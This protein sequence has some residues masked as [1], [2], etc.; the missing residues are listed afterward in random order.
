MPIKQSKFIVVSCFACCMV[1][2][3][4]AQPSANWYFGNKAAIKF[5]P[6]GPV[7]IT[8]SQMST[9]E[10]CS[11]ISDENGNLLFY[12]DGQ[13]VWNKNHD[14]MV[15]GT[16]LKGGSSSAQSSIVLPAPGFLNRYYIFTAAQNGDIDRY[17]CYNIVEMGLQGGLGEVVQKNIVFDTICSERIT[18]ATHSNG[19]D[20]WVITNNL[21]SNTFKAFKL[22]NTG[23]S[24]MPIVTNIGRNV[25]QVIGM[26]KVSPDGKWL[27]QTTFGTNL[28]TQLFKFD[29]NT[30]ILSNCI[31]LNI[32]FDCP[33]GCS[34]SPNSK[35]LYIG[36]WVSCPLNSNNALL[37]FT[38]DSEMESVINTSRTFIP[39][40]SISFW[41]LG[42][43]S[44][45][46]DN[47]IYIARS[48][49]ERLS[50]LNN[51]NDTATNIIFTDIAVA[52]PS[53]T[54]SYYGLPNFYNSIN[55]PPQI[56]I[57]I[58]TV[59]CLTY[60]FS[61]SSSTNY[62]YQGIYKWDFGD[63]SMQSNDSIAT[64]SFVRT[65]N[66][67]FLVKFNF[68]SP[69]SSLN[70]NLQRWLVLPKKPVA[71]FSAIT[72]GCIRDSVGFINN[73]TSTNGLIINQYNWWLGDGSTNNTFAPVKKYADTGTYVIQLLVKDT[74]GCIS[75]TGR[76]TLVLNK[77]TIANFELQGPYCTGVALLATD[78][79]KAYNTSIANW[80][81]GW[82]NGNTYSSTTGGNFTP[83][84]T[85]EGWFTIKAVVNSLEGCLSDTLVKNYFIYNKPIANFILPKSCVLD[86]SNF[87]NSSS[88]AGISN[89]NYW[90]WDFGISNTLTDT[91]RTANTSYQYN[92]AA[93][94]PVKL[95]VKTTEGCTDSITQ[96]FTVNGALPKPK[97]NFINNPI[98]GRDS[99]TFFNQSTVDFGSI[100]R[101]EINWGA[102]INI[103]NNP[104]LNTIY[105][106]K[107]PAF[108]TPAS[109]V[110]PI[111]FKAYS[112][113]SCV[114]ELDTFIV[115]KAQPKVSFTLPQATICGNDLPLLLNQGM[116]LNGAL[117]TFS[118]G[119]TGVNTLSNNVYQFSPNSVTPNNSIN[120][121]YKFTTP[122]GCTDSVNQSIQVLPYPT[123]NAGPDRTMLE[124]GQIVVLATANG[125]GLR[126]LWTPVQFTNN[127]NLLQPTI[128]INRDTS[129]WLTITNNVGCVDSSSVKIKVIGSLVVP[130]AFSPNNDG[131]ND[132][133]VI[134][135]LETYTNCEV[136]I[137]NRQGQQIFSSI[138]YNTPWDGTLNGQP[139]PIG[140]YYYIINPRKGRSRYTGWVQL[141]R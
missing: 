125:T 98:C 103:D 119:G 89:I 18:A 123:A 136:L 50:C 141:I 80:W 128:S 17:Y 16:G 34:F 19:T 41:R 26:C 22:S 108:G 7:A 11:T 38:I 76:L 35:R 8:G 4:I 28:P 75:D 93:Q 70:I 110:Q 32:P 47:K 91:A 104:A 86:N 111:K 30:G 132:K 23:L 9:L 137:F 65:A 87:I 36:S 13:T 27:I 67:S 2:L 92:S 94:Y 14:V 61:F 1:L 39:I 29:S 133:W 69:D 56:N 105:Q 113:I 3:G 90:K 62:N 5:T 139:L 107:Y 53:P 12:T 96:N 106:Y 99:V 118:Y 120:I 10:G 83:T 55:V 81:Y 58:D 6:T 95:W 101:T 31:N 43:L 24:S 44:I 88:I 51:P 63:G 77:K 78:S 117:G 131:I 49:S 52:L 64:H 73:S 129:L 21:N 33:Y 40:P 100:T 116:E 126:Y 138:G 45:G 79:A 15:N 20:F 102:F 66:D 54:G 97:L 112:G 25:T 140:T 68:R 60:K 85:A 37:Q 46:L 84:F 74:L 124:G 59:S 72:N 134:P 114:S 115:L 109:I 121:Q 130:N 127:P 71:A 48:F 135:L 42:D 122:A 82:N 57:K